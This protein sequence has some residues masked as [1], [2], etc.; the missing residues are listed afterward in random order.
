MSCTDFRRYFRLIKERKEEI[1][2]L[3]GYKRDVAS[4]TAPNIVKNREKL[5]ADFNQKISEAQSEIQDFQKKY[6]ECLKEFQEYSKKL[7]EKKAAEEKAAAEKKAAEEKAAKEKKEAEE[8]AKANAQPT[9]AQ[10]TKANPQTPPDKPESTEQPKITKTEVEKKSVSEDQSAVSA[11]TVVSSTPSQQAS[12]E[13]KAELIRSNSLNEFATYNYIIELQATD[14]KGLQRFQQTEQYHEEDW[15]TLISTAGGVGGIPALRSDQKTDIRWFQ[16]EYYLDD[17]EF[18]SVV[19]VTNTAR[20]TADL[21]VNFNIIEPYGINFIQELWEYNAESLG[22]TNWSE[23]CYL[24]RVTFKG[25][26]DQGALV[27]SD[28]VKYL[29]IKIINIEVKLNE[30]GSTYTVSAF[31]YNNQAVDKKYGVLTKGVQCEGSTVKEILLGK[32]GKTNITRQDG[33]V[34]LDNI[35]SIYNPPNLKWVL[36]QEVKSEAESNTVVDTDPN[37]N[38]VLTTQ[39]D[40]EFVGKLGNQIAE[41]L[42]IKPEENQSKDTSMNLPDNEIEAQMLK[43]LA[44]YQFLGPRNNTGIKIR[45]EDQKVNFNPGQITEILSQII[46]NS[47]YITKQ[48]SDFR[49]NYQEAIKETDPT[50]RKNKLSILK[51][52]FYWFRIVPKVYNIGRQ[53]DL[54][55]NLSQKRIVYQIIGYEIQNAK[56]VGGYLV[57]SSKTSDIEKSVVKEY[58][59]FFTGK[60]SE[61]IRLDINLNTNYWSYRP[62]NIQVYGQATGVKPL[63][64]ESEKTNINPNRKNLSDPH[65]VRGVVAAVNP[66]RS[67][68]GVGTATADRMLAG[69]V[70]SSIYNQVTQLLVEMEIMGDPDLFKQDGVYKTFTESQDDEVPIIFDTQEKYVKLTFTNPRDID[71]ATGTL[72]KKYSKTN[73]VVFSGL[74]VIMK[75]DNFFKQG[76]FTQQV[77]LRRVISDPEDQPPEVTKVQDNSA[78]NPMFAGMSPDY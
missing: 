46:I 70:A 63:D 48:I 54:S 30:S 62:R 66:E 26:N 22:F 75:I 38:S 44:S 50:E 47:E 40:F 19:G 29:P 45:L 25:Y 17:L 55:T 39:Y 8:K 11:A 60:N 16:K 56:D 33:Q 42:I 37:T 67:P 41:S 5:L 6:D 14:L 27:Q 36:N 71:D 28:I 57:N 15:V 4:S 61:I 18:T 7:E 78:S 58:N 69:Q 65:N 72:D 20:A 3:E 49:K 73:E 10:E 23:T 32:N 52:P 74:Y 53:I 64:L 76:K 2:A 31:V 59:Y 24:L 1:L 77:T 13:P 34:I 43:N 21:L 51:N 35:E 9:A 68:V 12:N